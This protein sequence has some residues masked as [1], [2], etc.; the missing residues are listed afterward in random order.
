MQ[1]IKYD[2]EI[3][4]MISFAKFL[5]D[6]WSPNDLINNICDKEDADENKE[7]EADI[8][9]DDKGSPSPLEEDDSTK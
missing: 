6:N 2:A 3:E 1:S 5:S 8:G 7:T 9:T 4:T